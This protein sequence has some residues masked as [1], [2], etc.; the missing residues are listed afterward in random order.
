MQVSMRKGEPGFENF[1]PELKYL[2]TLDDRPVFR[3]L[4]FDTEAGTVE[5][6]ASSLDRE[7]VIDERENDMM[8]TILKGRVAFTTEP[9][10]KPLNALH[11]SLSNSERKKYEKVW[12]RPEYRESSPGARNVMPAIAQLELQPSEFLV[13]FGSGSGK[14]LDALWTLGFKSCIGVDIAF[15]AASPEFAVSYPV[16]I[17]AIHELPDINGVQAGTCIDVME[18]LPE[19]LVDATLERIANIAPRTYFRIA[20][21]DET[22]GEAFGVGKLHLTIKSATWWAKKLSEHFGEV[23]EVDSGEPLVAAFLVHTE[24]GE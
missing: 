22:Y 17:S 13:D 20:L 2:V 24:S 3:C 4:A 7:Y 18:H 1:N 23:E 8:R 14:M 9:R 12:T 11:G 16:I 5:V 10:P 19:E 6:F 21:F 15:N